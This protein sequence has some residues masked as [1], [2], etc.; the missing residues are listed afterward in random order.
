MG[1]IPSLNLWVSIQIKIPKHRAMAT[2]HDHHLFY[3]GP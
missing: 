3:S 2:E 1:T